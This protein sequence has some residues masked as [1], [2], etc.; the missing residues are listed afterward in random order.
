[1]EYSTRISDLPEN[2]TLGQ[3][4]MG[5]GMSVG[6][7]GQGMGQSS[8]FAAENGLDLPSLPTTYTQMNVH[9]NPYGQGP[10][11]QGMIPPPQQTYVHKA[12][13][14]G[15]NSYLGNP[16]NAPRHT[17]QHP[18]PIRDVPHDITG[19]QQ[20]ETVKPN[21]IPRKQ[22]IDETYVYEQEDRIRRQKRAKKQKM[23]SDWKFDDLIAE[24]Q[25][26]IIV[27]V[28]FLV[29]QSPTLHILMAKYLTFLPLFG[30]T[31]DLT[32][33]GSI[34]KSALFG[35][36]YFGLIRFMTYIDQ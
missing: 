9:P 3:G 5:Q 11:Q 35:A 24:L 18:L 17:P 22:N 14:G 20:D 36:A 15:P 13:L 28:L 2:I 10:P 27:A 29:F 8:T 23:F 12:A 19:Y 4:G 30:E 25:Q 6:G 34:F 1:M 16:E 7:M 32:I 33:T 31:G 26:P 21:Y